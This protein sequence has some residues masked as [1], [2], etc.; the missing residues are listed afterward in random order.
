VVTPG[1]TIHDRLRVIRPGEEVNYYRQRYLV[2]A[3]LR[4]ALLEAEIAPWVATCWSSAPGAPTPRPPTTSTWRPPPI[5]IQAKINPQVLV[6][7]V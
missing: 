3:D 2:P 4:G 5:F 6:G 7:R 1:I